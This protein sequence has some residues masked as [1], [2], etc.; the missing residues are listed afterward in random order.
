M[1]SILTRQEIKRAKAILAKQNAIKQKAVDRRNL[2][3][4]SQLDKS[5][6]GKTPKLDRGLRIKNK[7]ILQILLGTLSERNL[8]RYMAQGVTRET[9]MEI[10]V[11]RPSLMA[12]Y[13]SI[14]LGF[15]PIGG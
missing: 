15:Q 2:R 10:I 9:A 3:I 14:L 8:A 6:G 1:E 5:R 13:E 7:H 4:L 12:K 11:T